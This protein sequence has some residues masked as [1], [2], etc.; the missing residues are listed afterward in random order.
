MMS[1]HTIPAGLRDWITAHRDTYLRSGGAEGHVVDGRGSG[2]HFFATNCLIKVKGR[3]SGKTLITPLSYGAIGGEVVIVASKGGSDEH[4]SWYLNL[5]ASPEVDFQ[6]ATQAFRASWREPAGAERQKVW[7]F[8]VDCY[9]FYATYQASTSRI[10]PVVLM[11]PLEVI[12]VFKL[13]DI[14]A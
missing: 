4:P 14:S 11:K 13:S 9:P 2:G 10:I 7:D 5:R 8:I 3:K 12:P 1:T 6:I